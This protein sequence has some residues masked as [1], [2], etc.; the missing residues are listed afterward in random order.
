MENE[1][2]V[3]IRE[4]QYIPKIEYLVSFN[5]NSLAFALPSLKSSIDLEIYLKQNERIEC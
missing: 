1:I 4:R 2:Q 3:Q 5:Y